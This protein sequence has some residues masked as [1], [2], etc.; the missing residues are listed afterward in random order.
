MAKPGGGYSSHRS[1][2]N[3]EERLQPGS[4]PARR[5]RLGR[6]LIPAPDG[7]GLLSHRSSRSVAGFVR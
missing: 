4:D 2:L 1:S 7:A 5:F 6:Y 3:C